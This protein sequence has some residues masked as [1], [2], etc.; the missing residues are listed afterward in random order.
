LSKD[1]KEV[2]S[3]QNGVLNTSVPAGQYVSALSLGGEQLAEQAV[4]LTAANGK[5][6]VTVVV[7]TVEFASFKVVANNEYADA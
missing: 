1:A 5:K 3:G 6:E 7:K 2:A 4:D